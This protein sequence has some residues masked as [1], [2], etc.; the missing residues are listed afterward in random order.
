MCRAHLYLCILLTDVEKNEEGMT[1]VNDLV[2]LQG[3]GSVTRNLRKSHISLNTYH[4]NMRKVRAC[5]A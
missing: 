3:D 5:A 4:T 1:G 2:N